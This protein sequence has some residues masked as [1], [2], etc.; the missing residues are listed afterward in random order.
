MHLCKICNNETK[1]Y[2]NGMIRNKYNIEYYYCP[3]CGF[4]FADNPIWLEEAYSEVINSEDTGI[5]SRPESNKISLSIILSYLFDSNKQFLDYGAGYGILVRIMRDIGFDFYWYDKYT[6]N[7]AAL[8][9]EGNL[10]KKYEA[11]ISIECF[12]HLTEPIKEI[13][14]MLV[15][16]DTIIFTT[17]ELPSPIPLQN[18]WDYYAPSHGQHIS[19]YSRKTFEYLAQKYNL[20]YYKVFEFHILT[21]KDLD[22][23]IKKLNQ[24]LFYNKYQARLIKLLFNV[25]FSEKEILFQRIKRHLHS[26]SLD[27]MYYAIELKNKGNNNETK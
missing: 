3:H 18:D 27:D 16:S 12:E 14:S 6:K 26:K 7:I 20:K 2:M 23:K 10:N 8:N 13:E 5:M 25:K 22:K 9:F 19:F 4:L 1:K 11:L 17:E 24:S 15:L 21:K